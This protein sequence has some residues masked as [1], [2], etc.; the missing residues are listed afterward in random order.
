MV[1]V[2]VAVAAT[3]FGSSVGSSVADLRLQAP[4]Y[5]KSVEQ[6]RGLPI[7]PG[8]DPN[9]PIWSASML[10]EWNTKGTKGQVMLQRPL[11]PLSPQGMPYMYGA[12]PETHDAAYWN[13]MRDKSHLPTFEWPTSKQAAP[14]RNVKPDA[15]AAQ[16]PSYA[17]NGKRAERQ[18]AGPARR[19]HQE[20]KPAPRRAA[21]QP[22]PAR[23]Q[24]SHRRA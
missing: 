18:H 4:G 13:W 6:L 3:D 17:L 20:A 14:A 9:A 19:L 11:G 5:W 12:M 22:Q 2:G 10:P 15:K 16:R 7:M 23:G 24:P 1:G 21:Q 8:P